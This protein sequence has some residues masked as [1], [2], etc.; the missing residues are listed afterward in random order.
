MSFYKPLF[1]MC[2]RNLMTWNPMKALFIN[3]SLYRTSQEKCTHSFLELMC[4]VG[5]SN[6]PTYSYPPGLLYW[7]WG[8]HM[9]APVPVKHPWRIRGN[10]SQETDNIYD[11]IAMKQSTTIPH[12]YFMGCTVSLVSGLRKWEHDFFNDVNYYLYR[13]VYVHIQ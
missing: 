1:W 7:H 4:F 8:N 12:A 13:E 3:F 5:G 6:Q 2:K 9:I 11:T 10:S